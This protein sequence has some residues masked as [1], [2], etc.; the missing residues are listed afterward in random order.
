MRLEIAARVRRTFRDGGTTAELVVFG[1][2]YAAVAVGLCALLRWEI[3][4]TAAALVTAAAFLILCACLLFRPTIWIAALLG[5]SAAAVAP[6]LL[7]ASLGFRVHRLGGWPGAALGLV[8]G[9]SFAFRSYGR[10]GRIAR[11][12]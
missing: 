1:N 3:S 6:T 8:L 7:L 11:G 4:F 2:A 12:E 5:G 10:M 9:L